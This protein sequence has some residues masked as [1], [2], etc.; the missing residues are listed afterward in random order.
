[1]RHSRTKEIIQ[2]T[3]T[4]ILQQIVLRNDSFSG[5]FRDLGIT[6]Y[7]VTTYN[8]LKQELHN[9]GISFDHVLN[10][11][12]RSR[13][14]ARKAA[15]HNREHGPLN[16]DIFIENSPYE[17]S[18]A[19][20]RIIRDELLSNSCAVCGILPE[21]N[22]EPLTLVLDHINGINNDHRLE[23]LRFLCPNCNSQ[24]D[25]FGSRKL[26]IIHHCSSCGTQVRKDVELCK[27]CDNKNRIGKRTKI[28]WPTM[29]ELET[30]VKYSSYRE[31][32]R[33][34][35]VSDN[36]VRKHLKNQRKAG[37]P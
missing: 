10:K 19:K 34:L 4:H 35:G 23:N 32:G 6:S 15:A 29:T 18:L 33:Q 9:R 13:V 17:R 26:R 5:M 27:K 24:T 8:Q 14:N 16:T 22:N 12:E 25:T 7:R 28:E 1:M 31:I 21:W 37:L 3:D 2:N 11:R 20:R 30:M 36:A